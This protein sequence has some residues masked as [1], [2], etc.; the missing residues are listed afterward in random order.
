MGNK[1]DI[2]NNIYGDWKVLREDNTKGKYKYYYICECIHCGNVKSI[3]KAS[4]LSGRSLKC[5]ICNEAFNKREIKGYDKD[6]TG[7][8]YGDFRI[9]GYAYSK[10]SHSHWIGVCK[11]GREEIHSIG[12]YKG[13]RSIKMCEDCR[14]EFKSESMQKRNNKYEFKDNVV[15]INDKVIIDKE[16]F[17][18]IDNYKRYV[19]INSD[20]YALI[21]KNNEEI[22]IHRLVMGLEKRYND[23][24]KLIVDHKDGNRLNNTKDNLRII[25]KNKNPINCKI[26]K[27]NTS[28]HKGI[29]WMKRLN[30][31][32]VTICYNKKRIYLGVFENYYDAVKCREEAESKYYGEY[33]RDKEFLLG[34]EGK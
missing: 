8:I 11:C 10:D 15:I 28:G 16:D 21:S 14:K 33:N 31:W 2:I 12:F 13:N 20:G 1:K 25:E 4:L 5:N 19:Y 23:D 18:L 17:E 26:Y 9:K 3:C 6:L 34:Q 32:Q 29:T 30:K 7:E 27:N 24:N 22:F